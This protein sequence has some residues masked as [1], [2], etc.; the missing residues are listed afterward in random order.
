M[1][2]FAIINKSI[3]ANKLPSINLEEFLGRFKSPL[4]R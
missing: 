2:G 4:T 3:M 1:I